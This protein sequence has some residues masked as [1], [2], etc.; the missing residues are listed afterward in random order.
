MR[1]ARHTNWGGIFVN[2]G[3]FSPTD[4]VGFVLE[5]VIRCIFYRLRTVGFLFPE[6]LGAAEAFQRLK[7]GLRGMKLRLTRIGVRLDVKKFLAETL[8]LGPTGVQICLKGLAF[9][10]ANRMFG[11]DDLLIRIMGSTA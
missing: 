11:N 8:T 5:G 7:L 3:V 4:G 10:I 9:C 1:G 6:L 2:N